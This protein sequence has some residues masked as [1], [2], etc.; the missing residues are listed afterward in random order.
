VLLPL[1]YPDGTAVKT[2]AGDPVM[3]GY[4][5]YG[6]N[7]HA[8]ATALY[9]SAAPTSCL[10]CAHVVGVVSEPSVLRQATGLLGASTVGAGAV[11]GGYGVMNYGN[12]AADGKLGTNVVQSSNTVSQ[13][14]NDFRGNNVHNRDY[15]DND[16]DRDY[17]VADDHRYNS[18]NDYYNK[19]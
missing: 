16:R 8:N 4:Q 11:M 5:T 1:E 3:A 18:Q 12:A 6:S 13:R 17:H 10:T 19:W 9:A 7:I 2:A 14:N 15:H